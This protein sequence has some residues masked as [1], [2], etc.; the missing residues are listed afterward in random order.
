MIIAHHCCESVGGQKGL[1]PGVNG[2]SFAR[3]LILAQTDYARMDDFVVGA[4]AGGARW[5]QH[6]D[7]VV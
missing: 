5:G 4:L 3:R 6:H 7:V 2:A 1:M